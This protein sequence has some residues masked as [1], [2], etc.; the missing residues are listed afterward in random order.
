MYDHSEERIWRHLDS[1]QFQTSFMPD[2][3]G[4]NVL[5]MASTRCSP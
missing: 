3:R 2:R 5:R 4:S 1:C